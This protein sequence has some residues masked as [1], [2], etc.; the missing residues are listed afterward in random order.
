LP[1]LVAQRPALSRYRAD[2]VLVA[3]LADGESTE[4]AEETLRAWGIAGERF[5]VD[6]DDVSLNEAGVTSLPT[7]QLYDNAGALAWTAPRNAT[8]RDVV[9]AVRAFAP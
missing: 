4:Q 5:L 9:Q 2:L 1:D 7:T 3:V 6:R 8:A